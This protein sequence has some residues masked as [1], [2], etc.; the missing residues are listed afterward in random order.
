MQSK[1]LI[2]FDLRILLT[3][4]NVSQCASCLGLWSY[5][6]LHLTS[7]NTVTSL[8]FAQVKWKKS[9]R[10]DFGTAAFWRTCQFIFCCMHGV[11]T[12]N[13]YGLDTYH[14]WMLH[15][16]GTEVIS[17]GHSVQCMKIWRST[18]FM[19]ILDNTRQHLGSIN[20]HSLNVWSNTFKDKYVISLLGT[21]TLSWLWKI[22]FK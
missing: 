19:F 7:P 10:Y 21:Y 22:I 2:L 12:S 15:F 9:Q 11:N 4:I 3:T 6:L 16:I 14:P 20:F 13:F 18:Q 8:L 17:E 1:L 5:E